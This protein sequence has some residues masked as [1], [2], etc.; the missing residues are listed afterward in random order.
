MPYFYCHIE[1]MKHSV[2]TAMDSKC[3][4]TATK[5]PRWKGF[6]VGRSAFSCRDSRDME[7]DCRFK[8]ILPYRY[9]NRNRDRNRILNPC[10]AN[11][12]M[13]NN[14]I[15][16]LPHP[17]LLYDHRKVFEPFLATQEATIVKFQCALTTS[18]F[19]LYAKYTILYLLSLKHLYPSI[20][21]IFHSFSHLNEDYIISKHYTS[22]ILH[23][24]TC[25]LES[26]Q[27]VSTTPNKKAYDLSQGAIL[28]W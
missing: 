15:I 23:M 7:R 12:H 3:S 13:L 20:S 25:H 21:S 17:Y 16:N 19:N 24:T 2:I 1:C 5:R 11:P 28:S 27:I 8:A 22:E 10:G 18:S 4:R 6:G 14:V 26:S 9:R